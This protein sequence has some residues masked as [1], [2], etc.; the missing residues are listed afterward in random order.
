M[1]YGGKVG[2]N[3]MIMKAHNIENLNSGDIYEKYE[4]TLRI[5]GIII[6]LSFKGQNNFILL[7]IPI[8]TA[9]V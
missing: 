7:P 9:F 5:F 1:E 6:P 3:G 8:S 4:D 2:V